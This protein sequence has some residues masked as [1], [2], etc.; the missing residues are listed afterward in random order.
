MSYRLPP[1]NALRAFEAAAR[2]LSFKKAAAELAVTPT[3]VSHQIKMLEEFLGLSLFRRLTRALELTP[4]GEAMLPKVREGLECFAAAVESTHEQTS[5]GRLI[6]VAPPMFATRWLVPRLQR[7]TLAAPQVKLHV[8][9]SLGAIDSDPPGGELQFDSIDLRED[10][11]QI[12]VRYG[13]GAYPGCRV[14]RIFGP[15]Y[16]AVC[17]PKLL[18]SK[19]PL[20]QPADVR[21]H[22]LLH[23]DTIANERARPS[24][25]EW[26]RQAGVAGVDC[27]AGPHFSD[28]GLALVAAVDGLGI[29]LASKPL[30]A[31]EIA[32]GRLVAPFDISVGQP[33]AYYL[34]TPE[35]IAERPAVEAFR[36]SLLSMRD[37]D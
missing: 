12:V 33:Y 31:A 20:R 25:E 4:Q 11:S 35:A 9:S 13:T 27:N 22:V 8:V 7:F 16:I 3:A 32:D 29:A 28:S 15:D 36:Q 34:V 10:D 14:D 24:W 26:L 5:T 1:L 2:H 21:F 30:V 6:V 17:S 18:K 19:R 23:D 37:T